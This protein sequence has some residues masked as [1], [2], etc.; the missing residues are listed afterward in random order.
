MHEATLT[1]S[2]DAAPVDRRRQLLGRIRPP[3]PSLLIQVSTSILGRR[4]VVKV[5]SP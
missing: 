3:C 4:G 1:V 5:E 2:D